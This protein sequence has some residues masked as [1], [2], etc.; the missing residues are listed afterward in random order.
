[1]NKD[2]LNR[3]EFE[4][5]GPDPDLECSPGSEHFFRNIK[6]HSNLYNQES[7]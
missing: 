5:M 3:I 7:N 1:M 6:R 2:E 4:N